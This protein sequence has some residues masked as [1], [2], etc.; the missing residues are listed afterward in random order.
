MDVKL[1]ITCFHTGLVS[2]HPS[3]HTMLSC[4]NDFQLNQCQCL[5]HVLLE[6]VEYI[7]TMFTEVILNQS[8]KG[9]Y[10]I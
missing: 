1:G 2:I 8:T 9:F 10:E 7:I 4:M 6:C 5:W 3:I